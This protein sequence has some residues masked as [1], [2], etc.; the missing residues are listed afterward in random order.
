MYESVVLVGVTVGLTINC[1]SLSNHWL[2]GLVSG[3]TCVLA[4]P[5]GV[6]RVYVGV[7][8]FQKFFMNAW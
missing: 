4:V 8:H 6:V 7:S 5:I 1:H 2:Y 3:V